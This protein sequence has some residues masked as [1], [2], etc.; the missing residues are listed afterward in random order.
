MQEPQGQ[1]KSTILRPLER[2]GLEAGG[3][4]DP[5]PLAGSQGTSLHLLHQAQ[6]ALAQYLM[7][8]Q[9]GAP[10]GDQHTHRSPALLE[11]GT[12]SGWMWALVAGEEGLEWLLGWEGDGVL[13]VTWMR[14]T[15]GGRAWPESDWSGAWGLRIGAEL[16]REKPCPLAWA[17]GG[18]QCQPT[19]QTGYWD[20]VPPPPAGHPA[21]S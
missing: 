11:R 15:M 2:D 16:Q 8:F 18:N 20:S 13:G 4:G 14:C 12:K 6:E 9:E 3:H 17:L 21:W 5:S 1:R 19:C 7:L 10:L